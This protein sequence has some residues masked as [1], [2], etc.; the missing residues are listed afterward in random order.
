MAAVATNAS[1]LITAIDGS[2]TAIKNTEIPAVITNKVTINS[3][4]SDITSML[5]GNTTVTDAAAVEEYA[6][7]F[8]TTALTMITTVA[9][10]TTNA[11]ISA[12]IDA[13]SVPAISTAKIPP[14]LK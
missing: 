6:T 4:K 9:T 11:D 14:Q 12:A 8:N 1:V 13:N 7:L 2:T 10:A 5:N 3:G